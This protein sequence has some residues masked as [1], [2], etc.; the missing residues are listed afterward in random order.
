MIICPYRFTH[1]PNAYCYGEKWFHSK[2][3]LLIATVIKGN[4]SSQFVLIIFARRAW[5]ITRG[6]RSEIQ[7]VFGLWGVAVRWSTLKCLQATYSKL[8][9]TSIPLLLITTYGI[10]K[11]PHQWW[12]KVFFTISA[13]YLELVLLTESICPGSSW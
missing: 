9:L 13:R 1:A 4:L 8:F 2:G 7:F 6:W 11:Y 12:M 3:V 10:K 5:F